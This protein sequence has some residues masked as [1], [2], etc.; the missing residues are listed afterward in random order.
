MDNQNKEH[1]EIGKKLDP[2]NP[3]DLPEYIWPF[4]H[5]FNKKKFEKLLERQKWNHKINLMKKTPKKLN[6][7]AYI[8]TIKEDEILN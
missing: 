8:M 5:S 4:I 3:K 1:Q 2:I 7:K 6:T